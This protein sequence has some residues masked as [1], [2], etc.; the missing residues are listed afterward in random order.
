MTKHWPSMAS[1]RRARR[2]PDDSL[3]KC[4]RAWVNS[5]S[6]ATAGAPCKDSTACSNCSGRSTQLRR[7]FGGSCPGGG[8]LPRY[9]AGTRAAS[10]CSSDDALL[11][12]DSSFLDLARQESFLSQL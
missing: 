8:V 7:P 11:L 12:N 2:G 3:C 9:P 10:P 5:A 4:E 1:C 6:I